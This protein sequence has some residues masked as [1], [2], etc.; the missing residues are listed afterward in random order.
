MAD[1]DFLKINGVVMPTPDEG[2]TL[3]KEP[4]WSSNAGRTSSGYYVGDIVAEKRTVSFN[5]SFLTDEQ[6]RRIENQLTTFYQIDF[7]NP[8]NPAERIVMDCYRPPRSYP[9]KRV[10]NGKSHFDTFTLDCIER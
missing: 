9:L 6:I 8:L 4:I 3:G 1:I 7:V 5:F 10:S 2:V